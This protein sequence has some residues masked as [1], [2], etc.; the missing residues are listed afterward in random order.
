MV[1]IREGR[2]DDVKD[3]LSML[4]ESAAD[5]G[6]PDSLVVTESDLEQD[7]FG[8]NPRFRVVIAEGEAGPAGMALY[9]STIR[10]GAVATVCISKTCASG[11]DTVGEESAVL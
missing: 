1:I 4:R 10:L 6:F 2:V 3:I 5:Q 11:G 8:P 9:F 7:G